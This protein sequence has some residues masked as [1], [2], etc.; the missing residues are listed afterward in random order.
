MSRSGGLFPGKQSIRMA[1]AAGLFVISSEQ[2][3]SSVEL[4]ANGHMAVATVSLSENWPGGYGAGLMGMAGKFTNEDSDAD[5]VDYPLLIKD[6]HFFGPSD[7]PGLGVNLVE[8]KYMRYITEGK[9]I[10]KLGKC[11]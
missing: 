4:A 8:E 1:E 11:E 3:G 6:G 5:I 9:E 2:L 10:V 7:R